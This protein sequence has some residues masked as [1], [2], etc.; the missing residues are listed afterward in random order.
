VPAVWAD[1][2]V[3]PGV[4]A[5]IRFTCAVLPEERAAL[6]SNPGGRYGRGVLLEWV[7]LPA[8]VTDLAPA[9]LHDPAERP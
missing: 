1:E 4:V 3:R 6:E 5:E 9:H 7:D 8:P 2:D